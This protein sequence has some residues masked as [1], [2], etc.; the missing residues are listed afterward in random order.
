MADCFVKLLF[1]FMTVFFFFPWWILITD[2]KV[3]CSFTPSFL[4]IWILCVD[5]VCRPYPNELK[6]PGTVYRRLLWWWWGGEER[7]PFRVFKW[8]ALSAVA[9]MTGC[10]FYMW[11]L[12]WVCLL[13][14]S[15]PNFSGEDF[16]HQ[17]TSWVSFTGS[18]CLGTSMWHLELVLSTFKGMFVPVLTSPILSLLL[19][20]F[21]SDFVADHS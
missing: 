17:F 19:P 8:Y 13:G 9:T 12:C 4:S 16:H 10:F 21:A 14:L 11:C 6:F 7:V 2:R 15:R 1:C 5:G 18:S 20:V 3:G